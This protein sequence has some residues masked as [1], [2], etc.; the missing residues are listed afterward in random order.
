MR[1]PSGFEITDVF[2]LMTELGYEIEEESRRQVRLNP[3]L[4]VIYGYSRQL[5]PI[6][7]VIKGQEF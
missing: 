5:P 2:K 4:V 1:G 7:P 6:D 3:V